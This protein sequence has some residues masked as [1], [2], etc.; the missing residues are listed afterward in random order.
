MSEMPDIKLDYII[1]SGEFSFVFLWAGEKPFVLFN[2]YKVIRF[3]PQDNLGD[4]FLSLQEYI[5]KGFYVAGH[6]NYE[7]GYFFEETLTKYKEHLSR[8][9]PLAVF[10]VFKRKHKVDLSGYPAG[11]YQIRNFKTNI[12]F[13]EYSRAFAVIKEHIRQ[14]N[15]YQANFTFKQK[16]DFSGS[17]F[18]LYLQLRRR[19]PTRY[20][21][22]I[23]CGEQY[24]L[25]FSPELFFQIKSSCIITAPMKGTAKRLPDKEQDIALSNWLSRDKKNQAENIMIVDLLRNDLGKIS[26]PASVKVNK[27]FAVEAYPTLWQM[28]SVISSRLKRQRA[29]DVFS[30]LFPCGSVTGAPKIRAMDIIAELEKEPRNIYTGSIGYFYRNEAKFNVAI[31]TILLNSKGKAEMGIG[32]GL[33]YDSTCRKEYKECLLKAEFLYQKSGQKQR[34]KYAFC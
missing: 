15:I 34:Q 7:L 3:F 14:G 29:L 9:V 5:A 2:P 30:A 21:V 17:P 13:F 23:R 32:S 25:S 27:L 8:K 18:S 26:Y 4:F 6:L 11:N 31:R 24:L 19:Q 33:V 10:G 1:D 12:S 20:S 22:L 16:F 28:I